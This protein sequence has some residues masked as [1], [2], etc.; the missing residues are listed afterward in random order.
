MWTLLL[1]PFSIFVTE[2]SLHTCLS[3]MAS[4]QSEK[5][6]SAMADKKRK[7]KATKK[8][9]WCDEAQSQPETADKKRVGKAMK[10]VA[11]KPEVEP[12]K[13]GQKPRSMKK[14]RVAAR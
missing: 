13:P 12:V 11:P 14:A 1:E 3:A 2:A 4:K 7:V 10:R 6:P 8:V 5:L 9:T